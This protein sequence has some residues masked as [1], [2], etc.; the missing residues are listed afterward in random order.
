LLGEFVENVTIDLYKV[1]LDG[2]DSVL[3]NFS[4]IKDD[5]FVIK[6]ISLRFYS[7]DTVTS[8]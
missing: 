7:G 6:D 4:S 2:L 5:V 1:L 3:W 8:T